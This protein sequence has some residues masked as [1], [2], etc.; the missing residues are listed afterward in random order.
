MLTHGPRQAHVWLIF[1]VSQN[2]KVAWLFL[3][4]IALAGCGSMPLDEINYT[5]KPLAAG[6]D[7][8]VEA[9][10]FAAV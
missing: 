4:A 2:M 3:F 1:D 8:F 5:G 7:P 10:R 6:V 9:E